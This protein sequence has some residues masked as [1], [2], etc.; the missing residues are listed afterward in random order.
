MAEMTQGAGSGAD[1]GAAVSGRS[2]FARA[3]RAAW[4]ELRG[5]GRS[6]AAPVAEPA[7][8]ARTRRVARASYHAADEGRLRQDWRV[9]NYS[10]DQEIRRA[11]ALARARARDLARNNPYVGRYLGLLSANVLGSTG[12]SHKAQVRRP[13][14]SLDEVVNDY[15]EE[16]W[17]T[18]T[19]GPVSV[20]GRLSLR[21]FQSLQL[22]EVAVSGEA[23]TRTVVGREFPDGLA[24]LEVD[25]DLVAETIERRAQR[26]GSEVRMGV[27]VDA[28]GRRVA[29]HIWDWPDY[30]PGATMRGLNRV[31]ASEILHHYRQRRAHQTRG[32]SWIAPVM[33][34]IQDLAGYDESVILGARAGANQMAFVSWKDPSLAAVSTEDDDRK[35]LELELAPLTVTELEPGQEVQPFNP[36]QPSDVYADFTKGVQR[37]IATGLQVAYA[38]LTGDLRDVNYSSTKVGIAAEREMW[39]DLQ[40]WWIESFLQPLYLKWLETAWL[41]GAL[42]LP[43]GDWRAYTAVEWVPRGWPWIEPQREAGAA[44]DEVALGISSRQRIHQEQG[45]NFF[46]VLEE[47]A[48]EKKAA[49]DL[50]I[51]IDP[52]AS[53]GG[54]SPAADP[55]GSGTQDGADGEGSA[56]ASEGDG[57]AARTAARPASTRNR[58]RSAMNGHA[59]S[60]GP[61]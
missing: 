26:D 16:R 58:I 50:G 34:D 56:A 23:F 21:P 14:G 12:I 20:S 46:D 44:K 10:A 39:K 43:G 25:P 45:T 2:R 32:F 54:S 15:L 3:A 11:I 9:G 61:A 35:P 5:A 7:A 8:P 33:L 59:I 52:P 22:E 53:A 6:A 38:S 30:V 42:K 47:L 19:R 29:Y 51:S 60:R 13:D 17:Q 31:P 18:W 37:R 57:A 48:Q 40:Q 41:S 1:A 49:E 28:R 55:Q 27:E 24:L 36:S 4:R